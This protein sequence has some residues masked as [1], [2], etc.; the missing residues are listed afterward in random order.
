MKAPKLRIVHDKWLWYRAKALE[1]KLLKKHGK[2]LSASSIDTRFYKCIV[3]C[4]IDE[5]TIEI[6]YTMYREICKEIEKESEDTE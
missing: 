2:S 1:T 6:D 3:E 4:R 5:N